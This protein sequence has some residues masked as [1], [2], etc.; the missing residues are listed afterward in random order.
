MVK[1]RKVNKLWIVTGKQAKPILM[2]KGAVQCSA[3]N[4]IFK[5][6]F[7]FCLKRKHDL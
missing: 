6:G 2:R 3:G 1:F 7:L 5:V 4:F